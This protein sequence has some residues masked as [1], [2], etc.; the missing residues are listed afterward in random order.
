[1]RNVFSRRDVHDTHPSRFHSRPRFDRPRRTPDQDNKPSAPVPAQ[2][3][4]DPGRSL[5]PRRK[6]SSAPANAPASRHTKKPAEK[7]TD[8]APRKPRKHQFQNRRRNQ[9]PCKQ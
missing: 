8:K 9:R 4:T 2:S 3:S 7:A 6:P 5:A 1:M